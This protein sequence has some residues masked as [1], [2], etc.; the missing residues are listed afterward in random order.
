MRFKLDGV[1]SNDVNLSTP[2]GITINRSSTRI[3]WNQTELENKMHSLELQPG[4]NVTTL[5][6]DAFM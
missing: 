4:T 1:L 2:S 6:V 3:I 5:A